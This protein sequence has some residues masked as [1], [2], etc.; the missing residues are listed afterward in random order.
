[1]TE[2]NTRQVPFAAAPVSPPKSP[3]QAKQPDESTVTMMFPRAVRLNTAVGPIDFHAGINEVP[4]HLADEQWLKHNGVKRQGAKGAEPPKGGWEEAAAELPRTTSALMTQHHVDFLQSRGFQINDPEAAQKFFERLT[5]A[6]RDGFLKDATSWEGTGTSQ[7]ELQR[8]VQDHAAGANEPAP[9]NQ[10]GGS[11][12]PEPASVLDLVNEGS[13]LG[14][15]QSGSKAG[16]PA[17]PQGTQ[18]ST[19]AAKP[20]GNATTLDEGKN[21]Q[22]QT[23][24]ST[25]PPE[26]K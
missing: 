23:T 25:K 6:Q 12:G 19:G 18:T 13:A 4:A 3:E 22:A 10:K 21:K 8:R 26:Q 7:Y 9:P 2:M 20:V 17:S 24:S 16:K 5:P 15:G 1:M 14:R 11:E